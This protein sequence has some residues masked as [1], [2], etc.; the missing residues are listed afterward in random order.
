MRRE[1]FKKWML[2]KKRIYCGKEG[3]YLR[4]LLK[5]ELDI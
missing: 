4:V 3:T 5:A 1:E 2:K